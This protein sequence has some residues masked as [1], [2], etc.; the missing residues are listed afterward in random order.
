MDKIGG[1]SEF[2]ACKFFEINRFESPESWTKTLRTQLKLNNALG[3]SQLSVLDKDI[4]Y[5]TETLTAANN[6]YAMSWTKT[7]RTQLKHWS[8]VRPKLSRRVLDK[9]IAYAT[10]TYLLL[11]HDKYYVLDKD[12]A[13]ATETITSMLSSGNSLSWTKTL[14]TQLKQFPLVYQD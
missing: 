8:P 4:A 10:E 12:I 9:D 11:L 14:R 2:L 6:S 7:L 13:Y 3:F 1:G 5:A